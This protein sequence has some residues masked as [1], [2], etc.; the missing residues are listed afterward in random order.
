VQL[1][2]DYC[3]V[4]E[5]TAGRV[6]SRSMVIFTASLT[7]GR[8]RLDPLRLEV[9]RR[10]GL[11]VEEIRGAQ[12]VVAALV[13]GAQ[14]LHVDR[15]VRLHRTHVLAVVLDHAGNGPELPAYGAH[16]HVAHGEA[17]GGMCRVDSPFVRAERWRL[18]TL[19]LGLR[20][21]TRRR[22]RCLGRRNGDRGGEQDHGQTLHTL[23]PPG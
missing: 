13:P 20:S 1:P 8:P 4:V 15:D 17:R 10:V 2:V 21:L 19:L 9:D 3:V 18:R 6:N 11:G 12:M 22:G 7:T 14:F 16:H 23:E 5:G